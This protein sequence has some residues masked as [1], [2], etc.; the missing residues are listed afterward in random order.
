MTTCQICRLDVPDVDERGYC[1]VCS[2][3]AGPSCEIC[4]GDKLKLG[5]RVHDV[6]RFLCLDC[7]QSSL[8]LRGRGTVVTL[9]EIFQRGVVSDQGKDPG[10]LNKLLALKRRGLVTHSRDEH[11][12]RYAWTMSQDGL[13]TLEEL[14]R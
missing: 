13:R 5:R 14:G 6:G 3:E 12:K 7:L 4:G 8:R 10:T 2:K 1:D 9:V 11:S